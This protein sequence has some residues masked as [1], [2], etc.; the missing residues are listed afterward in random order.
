[1]HHPRL[2]RGVIDA[3]EGLAAAVDE[4]GHEAREVV[5]REA[6]VDARGVHRPGVDVGEV[7]GGREL[8]RVED[9]RVALGADR[10]R[11]PPVEAVAH[12][13]AV[14]ERRRLLEERPAGAQG[15]LDPPLH[16]VG[17][18]DRPHPDGRAPVL[19][20][21]RPEV[22][23]R[24]GRPVVGDRE[25]ELH[26][27]RHPRPAVRH[28]GELD[29]RVGVEHLGAG[30]LVDAAVDPPPEVGQ[31]DELQVLVLELERAPGPARAPVGQVRAGGVGVDEERPPREQVEARVH[32]RQVFLV[33]R[34]CHRRFGD[35]HVLPMARRSDG[36]GRRRPR[37]ESQ[38]RKAP[39]KPFSPASHALPSSRVPSPHAPHHSSA[40]AR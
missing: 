33:G 36:P 26:P 24:H 20:A 10:G 13:A 11:R 15:E 17:A 12:V 39:R 28:V 38:P 27:E 23:R 21:H 22:H 7:V 37:R 29:R 4:A 3:H 30:R 8:H 16:P 25:V 19:V 14:V 2:R 1:M 31:D 35:P 32:V 6:E 5:P 9:V 18:I 40:A 34:E